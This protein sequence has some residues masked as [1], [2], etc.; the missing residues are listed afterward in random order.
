MNEQTLDQLQR[1]AFGY[2]LQAANP[3]QVLEGLNEILGA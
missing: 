1:A 2:F 3:A